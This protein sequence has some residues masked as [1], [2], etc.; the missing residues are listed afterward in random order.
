MS[1]QDD[2]QFMVPQLTPERMGGGQAK[3][4]QLTA[5]SVHPVRV[6]GRDEYGQA[7]EETIPICKSREF[8]TV[9][10]CINLVPIRTAP[11][12]ANDPDSLAI[13]QYNVTRMIRNGF[14][15]VN[16]CPFTHDYRSITGG[17]LVKP[18]AGESDCGGKVGGC[19][20]LHR[21]M[22]LRR[23]RALASWQAEQD[24]VAR[25]KAEDVAAQAAA[26]GQVLVAHQNSGIADLRA[27][28]QRAKDTRSED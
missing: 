15:P 4:Y 6:I 16:E 28:R 7:I 9:S 25:M 19:E 20:H 2:S 23:E 26:I 13:E 10:G 3:V 17:P 5:D 11:G 24:K 1:S 21:V 8:V 22:K 18:K 12:N 27:A 14:L